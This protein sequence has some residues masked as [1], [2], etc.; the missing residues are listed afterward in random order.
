MN[1]II[2]TEERH[3]LSRRSLLH[4]LGFKLQLIVCHYIER[5]F[6]FETGYMIPVQENWM[7]SG[8]LNITEYKNVSG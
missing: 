1:W 7:K 3:P 4:N 2:S 5:Q 8:N 6:I